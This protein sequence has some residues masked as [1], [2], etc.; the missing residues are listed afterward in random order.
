MAEIGVNGRPPMSTELYAAGR[1]IGNKCF[2]ENFDFMK[3]KAKDERP[4]ACLSEGEQVHQCVYSLFKEISAKAKPELYKF[5]KCLDYADLRTWECKKE[6]AA[7]E[8]AF[9]NR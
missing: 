1:I 9:Y 8:R 7:F 6:Q 4:S 2:D 3:C 5:T